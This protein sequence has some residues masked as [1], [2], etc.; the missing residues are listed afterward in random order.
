VSRFPRRFAARRTSSSVVGRCRFSTRPS[1]ARL[2]ATLGHGRRRGRLRRR[3]RY[4][5]TDARH[6]DRRSRDRKRPRRVR[7][8]IVRRDGDRRR[9]HHNAC[10]D[11]GLRHRA[12]EQRLEHARQRARAESAARRVAALQV[13]GECTPRPEHEHLDCAF[14]ESGL[15]RDLPAGKALPLTQ[16]DDRAV[17]LGEA[18][19]RFRQLRGLTARVLRC[20]DDVLQR[21]EIVRRFEPAAPPRVLVPR[22]ADVLRDLEQPR[23][24]EF[25]TNAATQSAVRVEERRL[26]RVLRFLAVAKQPEAVAEDPI[27]VPCVQIRSGISLRRP[28]S[29]RGDRGE[30]AH[31]RVRSH[32]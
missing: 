16:Q 30:S 31:G 23:R 10:G 17:L 12:G 27:R 3:R 4:G 28:R 25:R 19:E 24:L 5:V 14:R 6:D 7:V 1:K 20:G 22:A 26:D 21:V 13:L 2:G 11:N 18:V 15:G 8:R 32:I 29:L 9:G